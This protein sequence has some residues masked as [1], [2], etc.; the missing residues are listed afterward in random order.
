MK[1]FYTLLK[2]VFSRISVCA[3]GVLLQVGYLAVLFWT[4]GTM[5]SYSYIVFLVVGIIAAV[6]I[7]NRDFSPGY[8]LIWVFTVLSFPI[9]GCMLYFF[10][11]RKDRA[12]TPLLQ[13][14]VVFCTMIH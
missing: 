4:L 8:K 2:I 6:Y 3:A 11:G 13:I 10:F 12:T 7:M 1:L 9:F 14:I 5:F